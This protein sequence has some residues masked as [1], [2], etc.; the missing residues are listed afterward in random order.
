MKLFGELGV[1]MPND[2]G[3][4]R[5]PIVSAGPHFDCPLWTERQSDH[6]DTLSYPFECQDDD[7]GGWKEAPP[8]PSMVQQQQVH[9][10]IPDT[11]APITPAHLDT[12]S[13]MVHRPV[14]QQQEGYIPF[15]PQM[16]SAYNTQQ[17]EEAKDNSKKEKREKKLSRASLS[18][19]QATP[20]QESGG[21]GF[22]MFDGAA[23]KS[24][25]RPTTGWACKN[26]WPVRSKKNCT[27]VNHP[28]MNCCE[29][30]DN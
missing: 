9:Q 14:Q 12:Q 23:S 10:P 26:Y 19:V 11:P 8:G 1:G 25:K 6:V 15:C 22:N 27:F 13:A 21:G 20:Q 24:T 3:G 16:S 17:T 29:M 28:S 7:D 30:C 18:T 4:V 5:A 2:A